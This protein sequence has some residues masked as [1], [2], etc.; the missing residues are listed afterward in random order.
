ML[1]PAAP[2]VRALSW[3]GWRPTWLPRTL[4]RPTSSLQHSS[5]DHE[6]S[7]EP[8]LFNNTR[9]TLETLSLTCASRAR[10][11]H[12][13]TLTLELPI[14]HTACSFSLSNSRLSPPN[15]NTTSNPHSRPPP[16]S[17]AFR[18][19]RLS[20][21]PGPASWNRLIPRWH[22]PSGRV[23]ALSANRESGP[24]SCSSE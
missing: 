5:N 24:A 11:P 8:L 1:V 23:S 9:R 13:R 15:P 16:L 18:L 3:E 2:L 19:R 21:A 10:A 17:L 12:S 22:A 6:H 14:E 20:Y 7:V 4:G